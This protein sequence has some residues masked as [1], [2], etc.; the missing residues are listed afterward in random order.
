MTAWSSAP[1]TWGLGLAQNAGPAVHV[2][3]M[4]SNGMAPAFTNGL[5]LPM[6]VPIPAGYSGDINLILQSSDDNFASQNIAPVHI[7]VN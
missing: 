2:S 6:T 7:H 3:I 5:V 4:T 1:D